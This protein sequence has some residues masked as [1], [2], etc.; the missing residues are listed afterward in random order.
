[1]L[2][3]C[4]KMYIPSSEWKILMMNILGWIIADKQ[5]L[6]QNQ[7]KQEKSSQLDKRSTAVP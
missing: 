5:T 4:F 1:M 7:Q 6:L 2:S 3:I